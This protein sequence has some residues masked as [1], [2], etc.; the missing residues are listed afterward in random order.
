[1][2]CLI[3]V[4]VEL[5]IRT[6]FSAF[7]TSLIPDCRTVP[8]PSFLPFARKLS[9]LNGFR[10]RFKNAILVRVSLWSLF[11]LDLTRFVHFAL[12]I[13]LLF[14]TRFKVFVV[15][16]IIIVINFLTVKTLYWL[17]TSKKVLIA[18]DKLLQFFLVFTIAS[19][20]FHAFKRWRVFGFWS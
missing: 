5:S 6:L 10:V 16:F 18:P 20:E 7:M 17:L 4:W 11:F 15:I 13:L 1:M 14:K 2:G 19:F 9:T 3:Y 8:N 12:L